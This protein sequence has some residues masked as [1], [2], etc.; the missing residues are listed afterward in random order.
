MQ[1]NG[2]QGLSLGIYQRN[3]PVYYANFGYRDV[4]AKLPVTKKTIYPAC[5]LTKLFTCLAISIAIDEG[6]ESLDWNS[7]VRDI[8]PDF[9][10]KDNVI[11]ENATITDIL[12]HRTGMS[13]GHGRLGCE[14]NLMIPHEDTMKYVNDQVPVLPFRQEFL[15]NN[16]GY[17]LAGLILDKIYGSWA[18][19]FRKELFGPLHMSRTLTG[20][21][22]SDIENVSKSYNVLNDG[23][24]VLVPTVKAGEGSLGGASGGIFTCVEDLL[25]AYS[26]IMDEIGGNDVLERG[27]LARTLRSRKSYIFS[28]HIPMA[29]P[30]YLEASYAMGLCRVQ[31]PGKMGQIG[32]NSSLMGDSGMPI[33]GKGSP[34]RLVFY[35]QGCL[36]GSLSSMAM[37]PETGTAVVVM[38]NTLGLSDCPDW[39]LQ[40][41]LEELL[42][43]P[44][45]NDYIEAANHAVEGA[46]KMYCE[47]A[48]QI[49]SLSRAAT[50]APKPLEMYVGTYWNE[51]RYVK[52]SITVTDNKLFWALQGLQSELFE[53]EHAYGDTFHFLK[54]RDEMAVRGCWTDR[55]MNYFLLHFNADLHGTIQ[56]ITWDHECN[57]PEGEVFYRTKDI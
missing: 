38:S 24:P 55:E 52:I 57:V 36:P 34:S 13:C 35:H 27:Q 10:I 28:S 16:L 51:G 2:T 44:E 12:C 37:I 53:L 11:R 17:E 47:L 25:Q 7:R 1:I 43:S 5:S 18:K 22:T 8:L 40:L 9:N 6:L 15:Y 41:V 23:Q 54:P 19:V 56:S 21:P 32:L 49:K 29:Q 3:Q 46:L 45:R 33:I 48:Q 39:V 14:N 20:Q 4:E 31:L 26:T 30:S 42:Q 50:A